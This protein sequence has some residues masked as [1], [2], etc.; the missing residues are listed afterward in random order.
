MEV[1]DE[2][3]EGPEG[4]SRHS[5]ESQ[6]SDSHALFLRRGPLRDD[7]DAMAKEEEDG[8]SAASC[9]PSIPAAD[10]SLPSKKK[11]SKGPNTFATLPDGTIV[12]V[13]IP[14][15]GISTAGAELSGALRAAISS[16]LESEGNASAAELVAT[17][18]LD[19]EH[20][21]S[22]ESMPEAVSEGTQMAELRQSK[23]IKVTVVSQSLV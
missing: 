7:R 20:L 11:S 15:D 14:L 13:R 2:D 4:H 6:D 23:A 8:T 19:I 22:L 10:A 18:R 1:E 21:P 9:H 16:H 12:T 5:R 3:E 17:S